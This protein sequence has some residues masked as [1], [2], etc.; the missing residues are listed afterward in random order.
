MEN[1]DKIPSEEPGND[2]HVK[3]KICIG[4]SCF[5]NGSQALL[6]GIYE[7]I[8][9]QGIDDN[10]EIKATFCLEQCDKGPNIIINDEIINH[11]SLDMIT[12]KLKAILG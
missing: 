8:D 2:K 12:S 7:Y 5:V 3:I 1:L 6:N 9:Q 4:T 11:C 10:V